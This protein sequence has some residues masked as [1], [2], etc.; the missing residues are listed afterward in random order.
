[1]HA[2]GHLSQRPEAGRSGEAQ[3]AKELGNEEDRDSTTQAVP[4]DHDLSARLHVQIIQH[5][6]ICSNHLDAGWTMHT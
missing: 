6:A 3:L 4:G 5:W 1:M 2:A